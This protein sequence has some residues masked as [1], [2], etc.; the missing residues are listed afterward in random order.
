[1]KAIFFKISFMLFAKQLI[2][3]FIQSISFAVRGRFLKAYYWFV[4]RNYVSIFGNGSRSV[5]RYNSNLT[6]QLRE[7][8]FMELDKLSEKTTSDVV[9]FFLESQEER[10]PDL[11]SFFDEKRALGFVR[12]ESVDIVLNDQLCKSILSELKIVPIVEEF[13]DLS[14]SEILISV[15]VLLGPLTS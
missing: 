3:T 11:K 8:G 4:V 14:K 6:L 12:S 1:M 13:L 2:G 9:D 5:D 10:F 15:N 7:D